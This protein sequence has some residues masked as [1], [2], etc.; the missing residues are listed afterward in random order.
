MNVGLGLLVGEHPAP[1]QPSPFGVDGDE[2]GCPDGA[3]LGH[4]RDH[5]VRELDDAASAAEVQRERRLPA[6]RAVGV[7]ELLVEVDEVEHRRAAPRVDRLPRVADR[8]D[9][10]ARRAQVLQ[11]DLLRRVG[12]LVLVEQHD[13]EALAQLVDDLVV[14]VEDL[15]GDADLVAEVDATELPLLLL[16]RVDDLREVAALAR[17]P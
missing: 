6:R 2:V 1:T 9:G 17:V 10:R 7:Q 11:H 13:G 8:G 12:V 5:A 16:V 15:D 3:R 14:G 4:L